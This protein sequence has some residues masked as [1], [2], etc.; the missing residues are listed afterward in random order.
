M[1]VQGFRIAKSDPALNPGRATWTC[2]V[3]RVE[4]GVRTSQV[5]IGAA[6][7]KKK[8]NK[9]LHTQARYGMLHFSMFLERGF[10]CCFAE[11]LNAAGT[12][13][14]YARSLKQMSACQPY[15]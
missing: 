7:L 4:C 3:R 6:E 14:S 2:H 11:A 13:G 5:G 10:A 12:T 15:G 8:D 9:D 1:F